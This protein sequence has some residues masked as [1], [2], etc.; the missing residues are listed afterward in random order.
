METLRKDTLETTPD[1]LD[2]PTWYKR[3]WGKIRAAYDEPLSGTIAYLK[4]GIYVLVF[5][6]ALVLI[7]GRTQC[8]GVAGP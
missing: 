6:G 1:E 2:H 5:L 3:L 4:I 8:N 7:L